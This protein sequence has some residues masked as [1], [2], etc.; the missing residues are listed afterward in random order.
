M[1][2]AEGI[3]FFNAG[4][5]SQINDKTE[6]ADRLV[7]CYMIKVINSPKGMTGLVNLVKDKFII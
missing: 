4:V 6:Y 1:D 2:I 7:D 3:Y 5:T